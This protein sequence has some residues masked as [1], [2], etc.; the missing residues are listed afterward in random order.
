MRHL[1]T[2]KRSTEPPSTAS[3]LPWDD[4]DNFPL[5]SSA[6][7]YG[8]RIGK[9]DYSVTENTLPNKIRMDKSKRI[10]LV[11]TPASPHL[12]PVEEV[13]FL[14]QAVITRNHEN[15]KRRLIFTLISGAFYPLMFILSLLA[16]QVYLQIGAFTAVV[17]F[18]IP[19]V[20]IGT[21]WLSLRRMGSRQLE[22]LASN[23]RYAYWVNQEKRTYATYGI[24][25][26]IGA[27]GIGQ[28]L[29]GIDHAID[30]AGLVKTAVR[31]GQVWRVL[32]TAFIHGS[33]LHFSLNLLSL[34]GLGKQL[35]LLSHQAY[36]PAVFLVSVL[37]GSLCSLVFLPNVT[38]I[39]ASGGIMGM[40][41]FLLILGW[42]NRQD[43]PPQFA[44]GLMRSVVWTLLAGILA[45]R[46]ID[47]AAHI[48][49]LLVGSVWGILCFRKPRQRFLKPE[50]SF[51][52]Y[53]AG[54]VSFVT[55]LV[56]AGWSVYAFVPKN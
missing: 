51:W 12:V 26:L 15:L 47:N 48:G 41:G 33:I 25:I 55:L 21:E 8:Y 22:A 5:P 19:L 6:S 13:G 53:V 11:W 23:F 4:P 18:L 16:D 9:V 29:L 50:H 38:S 42:R 52:G 17:F 46:L 39:G 56:G 36:V 45:F 7:A 43:L 3:I 2:E 34:I 20:Q 24:A 27:V 10:K 1:G 40:L 54:G 14:N 32:T 37:A 30:A 49:G 28:L 35:E 44:M 31:S